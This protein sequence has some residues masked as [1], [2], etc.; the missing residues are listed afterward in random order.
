MCP[1]KVFQR[2][3]TAE[4]GYRKEG[5]PPTDLVPWDH[6]GSEAGEASV[7]GVATLIRRCFLFGADGPDLELGWTLLSLGNLLLMRGVAPWCSR[8][9]AVLTLNSFLLVAQYLRSM[10]RDPSPSQN[11]Q[12]WPDGH[13]ESGEMAGHW[14]RGRARARMRRKE[15]PGESR[16][17]TAPCLRLAFLIERSMV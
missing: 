14:R 17:F 11:D 7:G 2:L 12:F 5:A 9:D 4:L 10:A 8:D 13:Q 1:R 15:S 3:A 16:T 6:G